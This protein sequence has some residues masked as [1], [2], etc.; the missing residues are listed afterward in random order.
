MAYKKVVIWKKIFVCLFLILNLVGCKTNT[1]KVEIYKGDYLELFNENIK[2]EISSLYGGYVD[3]T[4]FSFV[5]LKLTASLSCVFCIDINKNG[6]ID[7]VIESN[8]DIK[9]Y[10]YF[11][12]TKSNEV[13][14]FYKELGHE[15]D[16]EITV[17]FGNPD[18]DQWLIENDMRTYPSFLLYKKAE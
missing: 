14:N 4:T 9:F 11:A 10:K 15:P 1:T 7:K 13:K 3:E 12:E 6:I 2:K 17:L 16:E 18:L 5:G 8:P